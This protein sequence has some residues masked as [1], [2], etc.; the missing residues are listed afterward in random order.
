MARRARA[1]GR[2]A[3][4]VLREGRVGREAVVDGSEARDAGRWVPAEVVRGGRVQEGVDG[5]FGFLE[6]PAGVAPG[7][8]VDEAVFYSVIF[9]KCMCV[10]VC[11]F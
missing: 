8:A 6:G 9:M 3:R 1:K 5:G 2:G 11:V 4:Q 7:A 10:C